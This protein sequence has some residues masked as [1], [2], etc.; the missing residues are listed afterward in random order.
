MQPFLVTG[1]E[2]LWGFSS[3]TAFGPNKSCLISLDLHWFVPILVL[4]ILIKYVSGAREKI[5]PYKSLLPTIGPPRR[6]IPI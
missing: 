5:P 3:E 2:I 4:F 6:K 1:L